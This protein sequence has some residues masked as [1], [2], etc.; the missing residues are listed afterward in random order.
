[1]SLYFTCPRCGTRTL[2]RL[3]SYAHCLECGFSPECDLS[4]WRSLESKVRL[5]RDPV[6]D[7]IARETRSAN[8]AFAH[9]LQ[10]G[11]L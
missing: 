2:E 8:R 7:L 9:L 5:I 4:L 3:Y 1:M 6:N 10:K 11:V